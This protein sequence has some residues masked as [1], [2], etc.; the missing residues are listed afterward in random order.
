MQ[1]LYMKS[2]ARDMVE[3]TAKQRYSM[4]PRRLELTLDLMQHFVDQAQVELDWVRRLREQEIARQNFL[5]RH[6]TPPGTSLL[7]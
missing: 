6:E 4:S 3:D 5:R 1:I 2:E 7:T